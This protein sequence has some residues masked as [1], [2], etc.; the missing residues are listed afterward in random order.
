M[1]SLLSLALFS[2]AVVSTAQTYDL[3][4]KPTK[5]SK[6]V[7]LLTFNI[8]GYGQQIIYKAKVTNETVDSKEDGS[9]IIATYQTD[10]EVIV[11]GQSQKTTET[12]TSVTTYDK[13][14][15][16]IAMGGDNAT[17][18]SL[19]VAN[20][21]SFIA[22]PASVKIGEGWTS[23]IAGD[24]EKQTVSVVHTYKLLSVEKQNGKDVA[25]V[26]FTVTEGAGDAP[27]SAKGKAWIELSNGETIRYEAMLT[28][29][30]SDGKPE[31]GKVTLVRQ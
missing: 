31:S 21:T 22:P 26:E 12:I 14:G 11:S 1:K 18:A 7:Y 10:H 6:S 30:P 24:K 15:R 16:P 5:G 2:L 9:Y 8:E 13:V 3:S 25:L 23:R 29:M 28:N 4:Y 27:A 20:L 17:P 19:R